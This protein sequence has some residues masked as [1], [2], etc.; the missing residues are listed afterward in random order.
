MP[1]SRVDA[2]LFLLK[3]QD[4]SVMTQN[5]ATKALATSV[6]SVS[7]TRCAIRYFG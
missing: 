2:N 7:N 5:D 4:V 1:R 6:S 3:G